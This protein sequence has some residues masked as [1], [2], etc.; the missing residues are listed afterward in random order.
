MKQE[1]KETSD[2]TTQICFVILF[3]S[4]FLS[5]AF[6]WEAKH[7]IKTL[8]EK[9]Q[10]RDTIYMKLLHHNDRMDSI[11]YHHLYE[12]INNNDYGKIQVNSNALPRR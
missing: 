11:A 8:N 1:K 12:L 10:I 3:C 5:V 4:L 2:I 6:S 7:E 9:I